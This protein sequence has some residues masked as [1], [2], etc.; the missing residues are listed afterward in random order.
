[1]NSIKMNLYLLYK[2]KNREEKQERVEDT[3]IAGHMKKNIQ[4]HKIKV[5]CK[6]KQEQ[7]IKPY[8][9]GPT[10]KILQFLAITSI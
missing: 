4:L 9:Y 5:L 8:I 2:I 6:K 7:N 10:Y 1:M 3:K